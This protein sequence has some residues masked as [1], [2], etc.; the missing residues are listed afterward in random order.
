MDDLRA[1]KGETLVVSGRRRRHWQ[2]RRANWKIHGCRVVGLP[3]RMTNAPGITK[4]LG[5]DRCYQLQASGLEE[6][7]AAATPN[8]S[9]LIL[10]R[11]REIIAGSLNRMNLH[12][13]VVVCVSYP[14]IPRQTQY[15]QPSAR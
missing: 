6:K 15:G 1:Q 11:R 2:H 7:L 13:R 8:V 12:G 5:F 14:A 9:T 3:A 4:D 10:E